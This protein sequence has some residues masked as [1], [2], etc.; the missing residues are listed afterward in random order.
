M[1]RWA[2][3]RDHFALDGSLRDIYVVGGAEESWRAFL[4]FVEPLHA[5][6]D[7]DGERRSVPRT[8]D[9]AFRSSGEAAALLKLDSSGILVCCHFFDRSQ[10][11]LDIDPREVDSPAK[12]AAALA[13]MTALAQATRR[14]VVMTPENVYDHPLLEATSAGEIFDVTGAAKQAVAA[15][16]AL[17]RR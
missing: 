10:V 14:N 2:E 1:K 8:V 15:D 5:T 3:C 7:V 17:R 13:L 11:E 4:R 16:G 6:F 9:E 12:F